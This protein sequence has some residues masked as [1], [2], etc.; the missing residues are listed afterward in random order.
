MLWVL[1]CFVAVITQQYF[2]KS[3]HTS[4]YSHM[5][6]E[7]GDMFSFYRSIF[8]PSAKITDCVAGICFEL[9]LVSPLRRKHSVRICVV[10]YGAC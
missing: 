8:R 6:L 1:L 4:T 2:G 7:Y 10:R 9:S 5:Y 3:V